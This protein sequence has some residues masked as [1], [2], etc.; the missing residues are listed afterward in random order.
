MKKLEEPGISRH[1]SRSVFTQGLRSDLR[2]REAS[3]SVP[4]IDADARR[5]P[6]SHDDLDVT[7]TEIR[8]TQ[9]DVVCTEGDRHL[10]QGRVAGALT[11]DPDLRPRHGVDADRPR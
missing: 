6:G 3:G 2:P 10:T 1:S 5:F 11:V 9:H 7:C 8:M 4:Q